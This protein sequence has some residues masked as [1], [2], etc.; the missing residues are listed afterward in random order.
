LF[1]TATDILNRQLKSGITNEK[2]AELVTALRD[3]GRLCIVRDQEERDR[4]PRVICS[5]GLRG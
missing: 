4:E 1:Q 5:M 2:L 3:E